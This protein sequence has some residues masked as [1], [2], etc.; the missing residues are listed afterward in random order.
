[1]DLSETGCKCEEMIHFSSEWGSVMGP[2][3]HGE[4]LSRST[5]GEELF[6]PAK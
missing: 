2:C 1:M 6:L 3:E 5:K 4:A